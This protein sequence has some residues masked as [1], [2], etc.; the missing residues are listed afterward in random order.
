MPK[1]Q[2]NPVSVTG[3]GPG[4]KQKSEGVKKWKPICFQKN[5]DYL[6]KSY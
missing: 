2:K 4:S 5:S 1:L 3:N 6:T